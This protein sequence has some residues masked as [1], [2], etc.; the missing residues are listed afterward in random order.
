MTDCKHENAFVEKDSDHHW[1]VCKD[2][3]HVELGILPETTLCY[4]KYH[5]MHADK[6][7]TLL[8]MKKRGFGK[9]L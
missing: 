8:I 6:D 7:F 1:R 5:D 2:C 3:G 9:G 4:L